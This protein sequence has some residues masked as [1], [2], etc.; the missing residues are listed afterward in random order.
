M[1][2]RCPECALPKNTLAEQFRKGHLI[3]G[4]CEPY[5]L[6]FPFVGAAVGTTTDGGCSV[7]IATFWAAFSAEAAALAACLATSRIGPAVSLWTLSTVSLTSLLALMP[8]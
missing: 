8:K 1:P 6:G 7:A 3:Q 5:S 2:V 4:A